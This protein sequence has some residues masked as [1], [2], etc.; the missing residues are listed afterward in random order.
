MTKD[1]LGKELKIKLES[2]VTASWRSPSNIA[3]VKYWGK[4]ERQLPMNPSIS[5]TL[6]SAFTETRLTASALNTNELNKLEFFFEGIPNASFGLRISNFLESIQDIFP[7]LKQVHLRIDTRNTFPHSAGIA[8]SA[9]A[10]SALALCLCSLEEKL[11]GQ[12]ITDFFHK[13]SFIAR[14]G[15][16]SACRSIYGGITLWGETP[17]YKGSSNMYAVPVTPIHSNFSG[18]RDAIILVSKDEKKVSS[19]KGHGKMEVHPFANARFQQAFSNT[20]M[21]LEALK[22]GDRAAFMRIAETEAMTLH[23]LMMTSEPGFILMEPET[24]RIINRIQQIREQKG[25]DI[26]FTLDAGPNI[27]LLYF[28]EDNEQV[29]KLIVEDLLINNKQNNWIDDTIGKGPEMID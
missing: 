24:V 8:S 1:Y 27:H 12:K 10:F 26:C 18:L 5:M 23:S 22:N 11:T 15:S 6:N 7:F 21:L 29:R 3:I 20:T 2:P 28:D 19:S 9:S 4:K 13:A 25:I 14:L 17:S 16:G